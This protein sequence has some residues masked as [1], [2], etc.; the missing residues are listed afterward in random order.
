MLQR[1]E[2]MRKDRHLVSQSTL[3]AALLSLLPFPLGSYPFLS[4]RHH[5]QGLIPAGM[6]WSNSCLIFGSGNDVT[7]VIQTFGDAVESDFSER[8]LNEGQQVQKK[9]KKDK[10]RQSIKGDK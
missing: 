5:Q 4:P 6:C 9:K 8:H 10:I 3:D 7:R 1:L 2:A